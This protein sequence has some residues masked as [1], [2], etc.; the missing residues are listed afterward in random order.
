MLDW[1][2]LE[3]PTQ[4]DGFSLMPFLTSTKAPLNWRTEV[5]W[6]FDFR[7]IVDPQVE[8]ALNINQ[9]QCALNVIRDDH[10]K[11]VHFTALPPLFFDLQKDPN[12]FNNLAD[13]P[14]YQG[15]VLK[16]AQKL[17]SWRMNHD[18]RTLTQTWLSE[19]GPVERNTPLM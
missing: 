4:C 14:N 7:E 12:E 16:Y 9:H 18:E 13:D 10:Y 3:T 17:I 15:L 6:E 5:H 1:L 11:Y 8:Q 19:H 2:G